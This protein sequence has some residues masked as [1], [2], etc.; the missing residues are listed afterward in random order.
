MSALTISPFA[1][2][3]GTNSQ[4]ERSV[5]NL[6][7]VLSEWRSDAAALRRNGEARTADR[8]ERYAREIEEAAG[9]FLT[10]LTEERAAERSG[11][12][13][14]WLRARFH[15]L[16][17]DGLARIRAGDG[18]RIYCSAAVPRARDSATRRSTQIE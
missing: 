18:A 2:S 15:A 5:K 9:V 6:E 17:L 1:K 10:W 8:L 14:G 11:H 4:R 12:T 13:A 7:E 16:R 3:R